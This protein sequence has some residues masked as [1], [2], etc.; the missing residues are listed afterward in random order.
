VRSVCGLCYGGAPIGPVYSYGCGLQA[1]QT[2]CAHHPRADTPEIDSGAADFAAVGRPQRVA[3]GGSPSDIGYQL[4][5]TPAYSRLRA[6]VNV[7]VSPRVR[8]ALKSPRRPTAITVRHR[9]KYFRGASPRRCQLGWDGLS[10]SPGALQVR[11]NSGAIEVLAPP[12]ASLR[13]FSSSSK[14]TEALTW[15]AE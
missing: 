14:P 11:E 10:I 2:F 7:R 1:S 12:Q 13:S 6:Q 9:L 3:A 5:E 4:R 15:P 8:A